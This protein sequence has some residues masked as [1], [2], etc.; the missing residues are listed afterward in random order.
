MAAKFASIKLI[1][2]EELLCYVLDV[3]T[4]NEHTYIHIKN[5]LLVSHS[6]RRRSSSRK[7]YK[8]SPWKIFTDSHEYELDATSILAV[9][10][11]RD[12]ALQKEH[13]T[14]FLKERPQ[15]QSKQDEN[16]GY[17]GSVEEFKKSLEKIYTLDAD[18]SS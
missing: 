6:E 9:S 3:Y 11:V 5:P 17:I 13:S 18:S 8:L 2:G 15:L 1:T 4:E 12:V 10:A 7:Y 16:L 14:H